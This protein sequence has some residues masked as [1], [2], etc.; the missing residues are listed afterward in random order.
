M[1]YYGVW[2]MEF[3]KKT[4]GGKHA[5]YMTDKGYKVRKPLGVVNSALGEDL[6]KANVEDF[7]EDFIVDKEMVEKFNKRVKKSLWTRIKEW[8]RCMFL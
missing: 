6:D 2:N 5:W 8:V 3:I 7:V 1:L 4:A